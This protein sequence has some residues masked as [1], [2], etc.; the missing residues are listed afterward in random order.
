MLE[1]VLARL[2]HATGVVRGC[3]SGAPHVCV[4]EWCSW[5][6]ARG[7]SAATL[8]IRS[9]NVGCAARHAGVGP[10]E[11]EGDQLVAFLDRDMAAWSRS[12]YVTSLRARGQWLATTGR[13]THDPAAGMPR[14][15]APRGVPRPTTEADLE[16][17]IAVAD[18]RVRLM[19]LLVV[20]LGAYAGLRVH[21]IAK[22][23]G[24][25]VTEHQLYVDGKGGCERSCR[26]TRG[27]GR[28]RKR[29]RGR[30]GGSRPDTT[31]ETTSSRTPSPE[32]SGGRWPGR[33]YAARRTD[34]AIVKALRC[35]EPPAATCGSLRS[36]CGTR[37]RP[38][39][40]VTRS[41]RTPPSSQR[42]SAWRDRVARGCLGG[43]VDNDR[44][45]RPPSP[46]AGRRACRR[47]LGSGGVAAP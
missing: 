29:C 16:Q 12:T 23:R 38:R 33:A 17:L 2:G 28:P 14:P 26:R 42:C 34:C 19:V 35:S 8:R 5:M 39:R 10:C 21:E 40:R 41:S 20:L 44:A 43:D 22:I 24:E 9:G 47:A 27:S 6:R 37:R 1:R 36:C 18:A 3:T 30:G 15:K 31:P 45:R 7:L 4:D 25:D 13:R 11:L 32:R 46:R